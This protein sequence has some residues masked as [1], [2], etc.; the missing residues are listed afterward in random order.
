[1]DLDLAAPAEPATS[2]LE[3]ARPIDEKGRCWSARGRVEPDPRQ[4]ATPPPAG[5]R[6]HGPRRGGR[7][8]ARGRRCRRPPAPDLPHPAAQHLPQPA[9]A[10]DEVAGAADDRA[11]GAASPLETQ[12]VTE[13]AS[14]AKSRAGRL[15]ATAA[16]KRRAPSRCTGTPAPWA[17]PP[18]P[19]SPR[20]HR[21]C[22]RGG[23][24]C[25]RRRRGPSPGRGCYAGRI[26]SATCAGE[27]KPRSV[28]IGRSGRARSPRSPPPRS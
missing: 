6:W 23:C 13:S 3:A 2:S 15:S 20:V 14:A 11:D 22:R 27:R 5:A 12:N 19:R 16:L 10:R 21:A 28:V 26:A 18:P 4:A 9:R 24:G 7:S 17:T 25:S 8:S 1:V